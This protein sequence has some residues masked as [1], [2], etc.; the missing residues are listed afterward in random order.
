MSSLYSKPP[1]SMDVSKEIPWKTKKS[2]VRF[3]L[4]VV[5]K[6]LVLCFISKGDKYLI[7]TSLK[8]KENAL[9]QNQ[10]QVTPG[11]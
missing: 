10:H 2:D 5:I 4:C 7:F 6:L 1:N 3:Y 9:A 8:G 11:L